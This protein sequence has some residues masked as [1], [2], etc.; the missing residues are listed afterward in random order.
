M[1]VARRIVAALPRLRESPSGAF[2]DLREVCAD[3]AG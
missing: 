1:P 2:V 3:N